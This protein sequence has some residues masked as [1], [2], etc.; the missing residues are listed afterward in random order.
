MRTQKIDGIPVQYAK[1][2]IKIKVTAAD[3]AKAD[4]GEPESCAVA[5]ACRRELH[6]TEARVH[7]TRTYIRKSP[8]MWTAYATPARLRTELVAFDR[9]GRFEPGEFELKVPPKP[10]GKRTGTKTGDNNK[11]HK[12]RPY[13]HLKGV[14]GTA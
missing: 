6:C 10:K 9:G 12:T 11:H 14:R 13:H 1:R 8:N 7:A 3:I 5:R 4:R 2:P